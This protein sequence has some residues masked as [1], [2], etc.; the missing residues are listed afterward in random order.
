MSREEWLV[1]ASA[2]LAA[3]HKERGG[4]AVREVIDGS[5]ISAV[6]WSEVLQKLEQA[7]IDR[8]QVETA[9][10]ALGLKV[11]EFTGKD[12]SIAAGLWKASRKLGLSFADRACLAAGLRMGRKVMTADRIWKTLDIGIEV[13]VIRERIRLLAGERPCVA[14]MAGL[15]EVLQSGYRRGFGLRSS[16]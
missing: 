13:W 1:D 10:K 6:N 11:I 8:E 9:L 2:L 16:V 5:V 4:D 3:I 14:G 15:R 7:D 12:A